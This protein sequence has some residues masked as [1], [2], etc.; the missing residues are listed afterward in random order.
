MPNKRLIMRHIKE[1]LR[2]KL[3]A[4]LSHR[5]IA[6]SLEIAVGTVSAYCIDNGNQTT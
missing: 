6:R 3:E 2:L 1:M 4:K 5:Q